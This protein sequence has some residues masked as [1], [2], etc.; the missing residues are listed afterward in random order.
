MNLLEVKNVSKKFL[1]PGKKEIYVLKDIN[2]DIKEGE[3]VSILGPSGSG[4]STLIRIIA[5]LIKPDEGVV[6]YRNKVVT[7]VNPG[8]SIVF[9]NFGL[10]PWLTVE[11]NVLLGLTSKEM[12]IEEKKERALKVIDTVGL[13]GFEKAYPKELSGGM[14]QRVGFARALVVEPDI[15][16]MD[17]PFS[18]LDVLTAENLKSD[19]LELWIG[20][21]IPTKAIVLITHSIEEAVYMSDRI[22]IISKDPGKIVEEIEVKI[23]HWRDKNSQKFLSLIDRIYTTL[24]G[25]EIEKEREILR[26]SKEIL[27]VPYARV[28]AITGFVELIA[29]LGGRTDLFKIGGELYMDLEDLLPIVEAS[30]LIGF[31]NY[32]Q[33][34]VELT[35]D[36]EKFV[37][38]DVLKKKEIFREKVLENVFLIKQIV[39]VLK[40]KASKRI[41]EDFFLDILERRLT[42]TEAEKQLDILIDWGRYA[43]LFTYD[44]ETDELILEEETEIHIEK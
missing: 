5:G 12:S 15:L 22:I 42:R 9:Q 13:D 37:E 21:K 14:K 8:V 2:F 7:D 27:I 26:V 17:E 4:K 43:E 16:L 6:L 18:S 24:T 10:F 33:G 32:K 44:D 38:A 31:T 25:G 29:D 30:E 1:F 40:S 39:R 36:G 35:G 11:E 20:N 34:D 23:P 3:I 19:L 41:S 28:G